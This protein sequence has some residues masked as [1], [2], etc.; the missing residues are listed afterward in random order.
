VIEVLF[1]RVLVNLW[2][3]RWARHER[4][5]VRIVERRSLGREMCWTSPSAFMYRR[6]ARCASKQ[7]CCLWRR[8]EEMCRVATVT[9]I[10]RRVRHVSRSQ[11]RHRGQGSKVSCHGSFF[12][13]CW[14]LGRQ[15]TSRYLLETTFIFCNRWQCGRRGSIV[16]CAGE[17]VQPA[18]SSQEA[19]TTCW[20]RTICA[21][22]VQS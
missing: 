9:V 13:S 10:G 7:W 14:E 15:L 1:A 19:S 16:V 8:S 11:C 22:E 18:S 21:I 5:R 2:C 4:L 12:C 20:D 6:I 3:S 17:S